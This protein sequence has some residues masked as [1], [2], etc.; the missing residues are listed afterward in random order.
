MIP[1][2]P[3]VSEDLWVHLACSGVSLHKFQLF[4][5][6]LISLLVKTH[7]FSNFKIL[8]AGTSSPIALLFHIFAFFNTLLPF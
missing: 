6:L 2:M 7:P 4:S 8:A 1:L 5:S 3:E